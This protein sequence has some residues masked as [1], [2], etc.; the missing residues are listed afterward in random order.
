MPSHAQNVGC[1]RYTRCQY[2][3]S[4]LDLNQYSASSEDGM[5]HYTTRDFKRTGW[6]TKIRTLD[7]GFKDPDVTVTPYPSIRTIPYF[8]CLR[9]Q[10]LCVIISAFST[11]S[12]ATLGPYFHSSCLH[13][14][15]QYLFHWLYF[16]N[17]LYTY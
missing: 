14:N 13:F 7:K 1:Y 2:T 8:C 4:R 15:F 16:P 5:L 11:E 6:D 3:F 10:P 9:Y 12:C 17:T